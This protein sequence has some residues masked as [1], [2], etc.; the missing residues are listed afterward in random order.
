MDQYQTTEMQDDVTK[1]KHFPLCWHFVRGIHRSP[2][3][4]QHKRQWRGALMFSLICAWI[5]AWVNNREAGDLR[6]HRAH[7]DAIVMV[8]QGASL[9]LIYW[10]ALY[11]LNLFYVF[12]DN[13]YY[14]TGFMFVLSSTRR[15]LTL[16]SLYVGDIMSQITVGRPFPHTIR[17]ISYS[18]FRRAFGFS[19]TQWI[20]T[21]PLCWAS[22][23][24]WTEMLFKV[25]FVTRVIIPDWRSVRQ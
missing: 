18:N 15:Y 3:N 12:K 13:S 4:S 16:D 23:K 22:E 1:W 11:V 21:W 24:Q 7:C 20:F 8:K 2:M 17:L 10:N 19:S 6:R 25:L 14:L 9:V 5:N